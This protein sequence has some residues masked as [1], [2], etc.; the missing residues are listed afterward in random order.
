MGIRL[1]DVAG[2]FGLRIRTR[3]DTMSGVENGTITVV[4]VIIGDGS[5]RKWAGFRVVGVGRYRRVG[6]GRY[7]EVE[8][9][10]HTRREKEDGRG[11]EEKRENGKKVEDGGMRTNTKGEKKGRVKGESGE[12][13]REE[14][15]NEVATAAA[16]VV[17]LL[18][19]VVATAAAVVMAA[20]TI[21]VFA[22]FAQGSFGDMI[23]IGVSIQ[24]E[25][26]ALRF[27]VDIGEAENASLCARIKTMEAVKKITRNR[28]R[29][30]H[31]EIEQQLASVQESHRQ[32][33]EDFRKLKEF[34]QS[35]RT[36][37]IDMLLHNL[38]II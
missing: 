28:E 22:D 3:G 31:I 26:I 10:E 9:W 16:V 14:K 32:D 30:A 29:L 35:V 7:K 15:D 21:L 11:K 13:N 37:L 36:L 6:V 23:D 38:C 18:P 17:L 34:V 24:E 12:R 5:E 27:R 8:K 19:A 33:R 4:E 20:P 1:K 25:L 2:T